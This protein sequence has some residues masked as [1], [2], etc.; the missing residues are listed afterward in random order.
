MCNGEV[1]VVSRVVDGE[2]GWRR[3]EEKRNKDGEGEGFVDLSVGARHGDIVVVPSFSV[4][5]KRLR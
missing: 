2:E 4:R 5:R 1:L 3:R